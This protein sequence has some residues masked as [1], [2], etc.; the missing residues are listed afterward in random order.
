MLI[1][2]FVFREEEEAREAMYLDFRTS[3]RTRL[4]ANSSLGSSRSGESLPLFSIFL[5]TQIDVLYED[6]E[7]AASCMVRKYGAGSAFL[8]Q[9]RAGERTVMRTFVCAF[10]DKDTHQ[11]LC[12]G[13]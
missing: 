8:S 11:W 5:N 9:E 2:G 10:Q 13:S 12:S 4:D 3:P 6:I 7:E 1:W